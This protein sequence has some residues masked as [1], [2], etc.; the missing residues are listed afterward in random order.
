MKSISL[1]L[2]K[3]SEKLSNTNPFTNVLGFA[4][5]ALAFCTLLTLLAN[6][7]GLLF[8]PEHI[9]AP[10][11]SS[12]LDQLNIF[13]LFSKEYIQIPL[14]ISCVILVT[15]ISGYLPQVT[16]VLHWWVAM[17]FW[18]TSP[19]IEGGDQLHVILAFLL[20]PVCLMDNRINHWH[21]KKNQQQAFFKYRC[22]AVHLVIQ[23][24][25][26][27]MAI[28]YFQAAVDKLF[29]TEWKD[30]S[31]VYYWFTNNIFGIGGSARDVA[32]QLLSNSVIV[33]A[34]SWGTIVLEIL[35]FGALFSNSTY[36]KIMLY[37][38]IGFHFMIIL[39]HGLPG[40]FFAMLGGL[41]LYLR[42]LENEFAWK[43][44]TAMV[45]RTATLQPAKAA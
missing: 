44:P 10:V 19:I 34:I 1:S 38:G 26:V 33:S 7:W 35:L 25:Q 3:Y 9:N 37:A 42:P 36:K 5:S 32:V 21:K 24:V 28:L 22:L 6:N 13:N 18:R 27:Q 11:S 41:I 45:K 2:N 17:S 20:I 29:V 16:G 8:N 39:V 30:G 12:L 40:F 23:V 43:K 14:I 15:V 4:R 31:A